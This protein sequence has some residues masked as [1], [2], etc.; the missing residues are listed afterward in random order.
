VDRRQVEDVEAHPCHVVE[1]VDDVAQGAVGVGLL[2]GR[3]REQ[4]VPRREAGSSAVDHDLE[5]AVVAHL[6]GPRV[7]RRGQGHKL[8]GEA[9][10]H[11]HVEGE[12]AVAQRLDGLVEAP[13]GRPPGSL[14]E[15]VEQRGSD[16]QIDL[17]HG[18]GLVAGGEVASPGGQ[19]VHPGL[20][21]EAVAP[22]VG[23]QE[24]GDPAV[25]SE[26]PHGLLVPASGVLG[27]PAHHGGE[28]VVGVAHDVGVDLHRPLDDALGRVA[29]LGDLGE[30]TLHDDPLTCGSHRCPFVV[31]AAIV[32]STGP[33]GAASSS[34]VVAHRGRWRR[35]RLGRRTGP[36]A[37]A[38]WSGERNADPADRT[39]AR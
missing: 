38:A 24:A 28:H 15:I 23:G 2:G 37:L 16:L 17:L 18:A 32:A 8:L 36:R 27:S 26:E 3:A 21:G 19:M 5:H 7:Q 12:P 10:G 22:H 11:A 29:A 31:C 14:G 6:A 35:I 1:A 34:T 39:R 25:V 13:T 33:R 20:D 30:H 4:L 9:G